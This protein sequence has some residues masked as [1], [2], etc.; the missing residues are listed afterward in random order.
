MW[1][2]A[3]L[4]SSRENTMNIPN[5]IQLAG[6]VIDIVCDGTMVQKQSKIGD[7]RYC[8]Q[9]IV[10]DQT[11]APTD[12]TEQAFWH[13]LM[14][15]ILFIMNRDDLRNDET[16]VDISAHLLYQAVKSGGFIIPESA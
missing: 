6:I 7:A 1:T 4:A 13:E 3:N 10:M 16:F 8:E 12:T 14:H 11:A 5:Q 9:V 15:W 2:M